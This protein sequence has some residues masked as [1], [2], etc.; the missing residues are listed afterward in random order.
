MN[1]P[2]IAKKVIAKAIEKGIDECDLFIS[3]SEEFSVTVRDKDIESL[4]QAVVKGLGLRIF[5]EKKLGFSYTTDLSDFSIEKTIDECI[6]L[7]KNSTPEDE[8]LLPDIQD[9]EYDD[10]QIYDG[11]VREI[12]IDEKI[13]LA[14][15][16]ELS[17]LSVDKR[18]QVE[19][20][21]FGNIITRILI[22][23]SNGFLNEYESTMFEIYCSTIAFERGERK[24][25][26]YF[27]LNR[28]FNKLETPEEVGRRSAER[29]LRSLGSRKI[30][31]GRYLVVFEPITAATLVDSIACAVNGKNVYRRM[32]FLCEKLN[33]KIASDLLTIIDD[34]KM[35]GGIGTKPF[36]DEGVIT[37]RKKVIENGILRLFLLDSIIGRKFGTK[38]TGNA[39][40]SYKRLPSPAPLNF[41]IAPGKNT[42]EEIISGIKEGL[43]VTKLM[44]FGV[45]IV[46]GNYSRGA[47]GI[48][49]K[50]G[51]LAFAVDGIT[52]AGNLEEML[53]NI[54]AIGND[55]KF[56][57][58]LAS[59][60]IKIS[61]M[62]ISSK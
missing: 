3:L 22:A 11:S 6:S 61:E 29:A 2:E 38:S 27:S 62:T 17:A 31:T 16:A 52:I 41:Y 13:A 26:H 30:K 12:S 18:I 54:S 21:G 5:K 55:L 50:D 56:Y 49:I 7:A 42:Q 20:S 37:G 14:R 15:E 60:T 36:D 4:K 39:N 8:N 32:S 40:R 48:W 19:S 23:N 24:P 46:S 45:D 44:G 47:S 59:P 34:G 53:K 35:R 58:K 9:C 10:L 57:G 43:F 51:E 33:E 1:L 28:F 25:E